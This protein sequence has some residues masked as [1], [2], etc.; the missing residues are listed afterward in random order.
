MTKTV[1]PSHLLL[2]NLGANG[3][4]LGFY[5][6]ATAVELVLGNEE[7]TYQC[8]WLYNE[9]AKKF[10]TTP[11]CVERDIRTIV[12]YIWKNGDRNK[13]RV[14]IPYLTDVKPKNGQLIDGLA[15]YLRA[16]GGVYV[17]LLPEHNEGTGRQ[18][19]D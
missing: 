3:S 18:A 8:K 10:R 13:L 2:R 14:V 7:G 15:H 17:P 16:N 1:K 19:N 12:E 9:V 5:Y 4:Y 6:I 11:Y